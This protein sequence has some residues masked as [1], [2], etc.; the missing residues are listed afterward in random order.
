MFADQQQPGKGFNRKGRKENPQR[1]RKKQ[2]E[3]NQIAL[4]TAAN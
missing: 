4:R 3:E 2:C 1:T